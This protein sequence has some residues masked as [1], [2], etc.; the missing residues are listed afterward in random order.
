MIDEP[1]GNIIG[2]TNAKLLRDLVK[3]VTSLQPN[4]PQYGSTN[5]GGLSVTNSPFGQIIDQDSFRLSDEKVLVALVEVGVDGGSDYTDYRYWAREVVLVQSD[6]GESAEALPH[7][8]DDGFYATV[9]NI[10]EMATGSHLLQ[11]TDGEVTE[12]L[13]DSYTLTWARKLEGCG[14]EDN[15]G[16]FLF[17]I[18]VEPPSTFAGRITSVSG[19]FPEWVYTV[20]RV[21]S[22]DSTQT[23]YNKWVTDTVT[24]YTCKNRCEWTPTSYPFLHGAGFKVTNS[25]GFVAESYDEPSTASDC[26]VRA[27]GVGS[28]VDVTLTTDE[29]DEPVYS[30]YQPNSA[31][32]D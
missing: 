3:S 17:V 7:I 22:Y 32:R 29:D 25:N 6:E 20:Q 24:S 12:E 8:Y 14:T 31:Q 18:D 10:G 30:F 19:T 26:K 23:Q 27:I 28:V 1:K 11:V 5:V 9:F 21:E 2:R 16:R 13:T 15:P 4:S